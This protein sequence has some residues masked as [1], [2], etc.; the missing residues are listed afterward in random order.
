MDIQKKILVVDDEPEYLE[1]IGKF[2]QKRGL[3]FEIAGGCPEGLDWLSRADFDVVVMDVAMPGLDG[4]QCML[5]MKKLQPPPEIVIVTGHSS[6]D[7]T[8]RG[9]K[10]GAFDFCL[11]PVDFDYLLEVIL[12]AKKKYNE[13]LLAQK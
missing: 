9:I 11:K 8:I 7:H 3:G 12:L 6:L 2:F 10:D 13:S 4:L 1:L 5:E